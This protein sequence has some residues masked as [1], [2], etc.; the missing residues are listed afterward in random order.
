MHVVV[1]CAV[2]MATRCTLADG[3]DLTQKPDK[4]L[5]EKEKDHLQK[6]HTFL[7]TFIGNDSTDQLRAI[8]A[9]QVFCYEKDFPKGQNFI[10]LM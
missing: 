1:T 2:I 9:L 6:I 5:Q 3:I 10:F 4:E 7:R 8:Y